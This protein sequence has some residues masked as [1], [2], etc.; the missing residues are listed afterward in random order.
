MQRH[1][2]L[3]KQHTFPLEHPYALR[4][5][6]LA[7]PPQTGVADE[8][9]PVDEVPILFEVVDKVLQELAAEA[10]LGGAGV[11]LPDQIAHSH[12][13]IGVVDAVPPQNHLVQRSHYVYQSLTN[14]LDVGGN[15]D[16]LE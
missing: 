3:V 9:F 13:Q 11:L 6:L 14:F 4:E 5:V 12:L 10:Q 1:Q 2:T 15:Q 8:Y 7:D 16:I